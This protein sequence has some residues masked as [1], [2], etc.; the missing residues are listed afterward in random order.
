MEKTEPKKKRS[1][2]GC[3]NYFDILY[4]RPQSGNVIQEGWKYSETQKNRIGNG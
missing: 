1:N 2:E 4:T 3:T